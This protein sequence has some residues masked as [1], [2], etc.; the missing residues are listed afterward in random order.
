M[1]SARVK[2]P[3]TRRPRSPLETSP[4]S[5]WILAVTSHYNSMRLSVRRQLTG[6]GLLSVAYTWSNAITD[7]EQPMDSYNAR[8]DRGLMAFDRRHIFVASY[9]P[10][11]K[12]TFP[13]RPASPPSLS[14]ER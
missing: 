2:L 1:F 12:L 13:V 5:S 14:S 6:N 10:A 9:F 11:Q 7:D 4:T 8:R 3:A